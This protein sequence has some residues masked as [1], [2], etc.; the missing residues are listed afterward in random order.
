MEHFEELLPIVSNPTVRHACQRYGLMFKSMP[1]G[2]FITLEDRGR[3]FRILKNWPERNVRLIVITDGERVGA[4]G[5]LG[6]QVGGVGGW[7]GG[8]GG[9]LA[10][11]SSSSTSDTSSRRVMWYMVPD[12]RGSSSSSGSSSSWSSSS[13]RWVKILGH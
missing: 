8:G 5:D 1:R 10:F 11:G 4:L 7:G 3:V 13:G 2:L 12:N 6:V 9:H